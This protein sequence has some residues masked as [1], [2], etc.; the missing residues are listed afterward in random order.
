[1]VS[2]LPKLSCECKQNYFVKKITKFAF[3]KEPARF[4]IKANNHYFA[5]IQEVLWV[6][7][8]FATANSLF[9]KI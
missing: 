6:G 1:M 9:R 7:K 3:E 8:Q 4:K 2:T 5:F